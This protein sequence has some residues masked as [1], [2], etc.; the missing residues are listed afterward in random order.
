MDIDWSGFTIAIDE[1]MEMGHEEQ[2]CTDQYSYI[3]PGTYTIAELMKL[4]E[5]HLKT[6]PVWTGE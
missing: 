3:E 6:C 5:E 4:A 1:D 2:G